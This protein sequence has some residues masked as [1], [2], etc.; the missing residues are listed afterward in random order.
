MHKYIILLFFTLSGINP[1]HATDKLDILSIFDQFVTSGAA[2]SQCDKPSKETLTKFLA[3]FQMVSILASK[4]LKEQYPKATS[5]RIEQAKKKRTEKITTEVEE[6]VDKNG[7]DNPDV[8]E[9]IKRFYV[10]AEWKPGQ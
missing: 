6:I 1:V 8:Q 5:E 9:A 7:C 2:A 4:K 10:Q 3:N